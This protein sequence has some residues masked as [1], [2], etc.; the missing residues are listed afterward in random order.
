MNEHVRNHVYFKNKND[1]KTVINKFFTITLPEI[2]D[3]LM[4][5]INYNFHALSSVSL[6]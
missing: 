6:S 3:S 2:A 5:Q 1:F 4:S